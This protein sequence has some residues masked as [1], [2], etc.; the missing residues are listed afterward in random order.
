MRSH[1]RYPF[2]VEVNFVLQFY[3]TT[4]DAA[5]VDYLALTNLII[6]SHSEVKELQLSSPDAY[7]NPK[8]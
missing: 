2:I 5:P 3:F 8:L 4:I 6:Y 1:Y 7:N